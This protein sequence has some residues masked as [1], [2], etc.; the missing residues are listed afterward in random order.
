[1]LNEKSLESEGIHYKFQVIFFFIASICVG[2]GIYESI[3]LTNVLEQ[4]SN[5]GQEQ[6]VFIGSVFSLF[7]T[8]GFLIFGWLANH[9]ETK[10]LLIAG[11]L[12]LM[13][14]TFL[15]GFA[16]NYTLMI[17]FRAIQGIFAA[18]FASLGFS[19]KLI[20]FQTLNV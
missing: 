3:P 5:V 20:C 8:I 16:S 7:Y 17:V 2:T 6:I 18:S 1:M 13:V 4:S 19:I 14:S 9:I 10:K 12:L 15:T 11:T